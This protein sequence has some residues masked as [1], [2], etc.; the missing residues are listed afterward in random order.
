MSSSFGGPEKDSS[1]FGVLDPGSL[2]NVCDV[3]KNNVPMMKVS[4]VNDAGMRKADDVRRFDDKRDVGGRNVVVGSRMDCRI[5]N[6]GC[7]DRFGHLIHT[8]IEGLARFRQK[9]WLDLL[10]INE[11]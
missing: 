7:D 1:V 4:R 10:T 3:R 8:L 6:G 11:W 9:H 5:T 2:R